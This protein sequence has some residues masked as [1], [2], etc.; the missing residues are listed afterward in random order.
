MPER[1]RNLKLKSKILVGF[2]AFLP[3]TNAYAIRPMNGQPMTGGGQMM[4]PQPMMQ[5]P[6]MAQPMMGQQNMVMVQTPQGPMMVPASQAMQ[7]QPNN[8]T[9]FMNNARVQQYPGATSQGRVTGQLPRVGSSYVQAGRRYYQPEGFDRLADSGLYLGLSIGYNM[10]INGGMQANYRNDQDS[11]FAPGAFERASFASK[12]VMPIQVSVG[13]ALNNDIRVD[14]SYLR[15]SGMSYPGIV[16]TGDGGGGFFDVT[17]TG[18]GISSTATMINIYY[19]LDSY[20]GVLSGGG[21]RPYAGIGLGIATNTISDYI[22]Y[23]A[24]FYPDFYWPDGS[25]PPPGEVVGVSDIMAYH[26]GGTTEQLAWALEGGVT[27]EM[28]GGLKL[29]FFVR[30][31]NLGRVETSGNIVVSQTEWLATG[32]PIGT[33][34]SEIPADYD[35]V[36]HY[37]GWRESGT[38]GMVDLGV[39]VRMQF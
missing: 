25:I 12:S 24:E 20:T 37:T 17:A 30:Y 14:F 1:Y 4:M 21:L 11:F 7:G 2:L 38:L 34:G 3:I 29:D 33:M 22:V 31:A 32:D 26:S 15:Y 13:A 27:M 16:Q 6:L 35:S 36:F 18:G 9:M 8:N 28:E 5:Q 10:S 23:D 39:R 19:N